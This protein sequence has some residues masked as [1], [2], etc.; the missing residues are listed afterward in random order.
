MSR[1]YRLPALI[2]G[3][4]WMLAIMICL[5]ATA[6]VKESTDFRSLKINGYHYL[7]STMN[8]D[9]SYTISVDTARPELPVVE[10]DCENRYRLRDAIS[11]AVNWINTERNN[12]E[13][14]DWPEDISRSCE[15]TK[16]RLQSILTVTYEYDSEFEISV[17]TAWRK[18]DD[19]VRLYERLNTEITDY[20]NE[21]L[22]ID[23]TEESRFVAKKYEESKLLRISP[24][25]SSPNNNDYL[26]SYKWDKSKEW[27]KIFPNSLSLER[28]ETNIQV[29]CA[30]MIQ[31]CQHKANDYNEFANE[32]LSILNDS[33]VN[34]YEGDLEQIDKNFKD[35]KQNEKD[36]VLALDCCDM[37]LDLLSGMNFLETVEYYTNEFNARKIELKNELKSLAERIDTS[38]EIL[39]TYNDFYSVF[40]TKVIEY[41]DWIQGISDMMMSW[42]ADYAGMIE[43][44]NGVLEFP[45][46]IVFDDV[47]YIVFK[48][49]D[50][51][52]TSYRY[53][54][55]FNVNCN[56]TVKLPYSIKYLGRYSLSYENIDCIESSNL[57]PPLMEGPD[58]FN[59]YFTDWD[60]VNYEG[61]YDTGMLVVPDGC[62]EAYLSEK[63]P[64]R[65]KNGY[66]WYLFKDIKTFSEVSGVDSVEENA[67]GV[68][69]RN[70]MLI[71]ENGLDIAVYDISGRVVYKGNDSAVQISQKGILIVR[72]GAKTIKIHS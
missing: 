71:N 70:G 7:F 48:I 63:T 56:I 49:E 45:S 29:E 61:I 12:P 59:F 15:G 13:Y 1:F 25:R 33:I 32:C 39:N 19:M 67:D 65:D 58:V 62:K 14:Y 34:Q 22:G 44:N 16:N 17:N 6:Q 43:K 4:V 68:Y 54:F 10:F 69:F 31:Y 30:S 28:S 52:I 47:E 53:G 38:F 8:A 64:L 11:E 18:V 21:L 2:A 42:E 3:M 57:N 9:V 51:I 55:I 37:Y 5:P 24:K 35:V 46:S 72:V 40:P 60:Y 20:K 23:K 66:W 50:G 41:R 26:N 27:D 36:I